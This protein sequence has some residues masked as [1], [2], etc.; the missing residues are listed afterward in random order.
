[1]SKVIKLVENPREAATATTTKTRKKSTP[2]YDAIQQHIGK[3]L[4]LKIESWRMNK[5]K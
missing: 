5:K 2:S 1:M 3:K 4:K